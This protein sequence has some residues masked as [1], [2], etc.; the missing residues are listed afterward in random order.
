MTRMTTALAVLIC[1]ALPLPAA[2]WGS[3]G[4]QV[5][6][7]IAYDHLTPAARKQV[8]TL[9][10]LNAFVGYTNAAYAETTY[11][12]KPLTG[13]ATPI[14]RQGDRLPVPVWEAA[15]GARYEFPVMHTLAYVRFDYQ[16][17]SAYQRSTMP[18]TA[19]YAPDVYTA[20][21]TRFATLRIGDQLGKV[22]AALYVNN[23]F[24]SRDTIGAVGGRTGCALSSGATCQSYAF[25]T[26]F[27]TV[28]TFR[29][30]QVGIELSYGF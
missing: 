24:D 15:L 26:P 4:H 1:V 22:A 5:T 23:L 29:P 16:Y 21:A 28:S 25:F 17:S 20:P 14:V 8:D 19:S 27:L 30:R 2:A 9:L 18:G 11:G 10:T 6:A 7:L 3:I 13:A 12:P